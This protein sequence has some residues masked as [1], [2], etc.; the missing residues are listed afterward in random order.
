VDRASTLRRLPEH[1]TE[2]GIVAVLVA[3]RTSSRI[4]RLRRA[5]PLG[6]V[7]IRIGR[8]RDC[9]HGFELIGRM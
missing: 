8:R 5:H 9:N 1:H 6:R 4:L 3:F 7:V 2:F